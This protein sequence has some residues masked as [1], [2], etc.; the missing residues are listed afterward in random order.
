MIDLKSGN[1][2]STTPDGWTWWLVRRRLDA[3]QVH[4]N[5]RITRLVCPGKRG[6]RTRRS[7]S[8]TSYLDLRAAEVELRLVGLHSHM[9][10]DVLY[11]KQV[12]AVWCGLGDRDVDGLVLIYFHRH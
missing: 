10:R 5:S 2:Q 4:Q 7:T 6:E 8:T 11:A 9:Q 12:L 1:C 3:T